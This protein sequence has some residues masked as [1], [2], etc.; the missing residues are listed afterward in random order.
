MQ[1]NLHRIVRLA[2]DVDRDDLAERV[3]ILMEEDRGLGRNEAEE[4]VD[5]YTEPLA[6]AFD[7]AG[8][9][10]TEHQV[11]RNFRDELER[12][13]PVAPDINDKEVRTLVDDIDEV[14]RKSPGP[15]RQ[16]GK[17]DLSIG[18]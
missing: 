4:A 5:L 3:R 16:I 2:L 18:K 6:K 12:A 9:R 7:R 10:P 15:G 8:R 1:I 11:E 17:M 13:D 14:E